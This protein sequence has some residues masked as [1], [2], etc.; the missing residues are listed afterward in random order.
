MHIF[1]SLKRH[2]LWYFHQ[3]SKLCLFLEDAEFTTESRSAHPHCKNL[4]R[5]HP[6]LPKLFVKNKIMFWLLFQE[7]ARHPPDAGDKATIKYINNSCGEREYWFARTCLK[8]FIVKVLINGA[9]VSDF[10]SFT[11]TWL[12]PGKGKF[13]VEID[14]GWR[15]KLT[16]KI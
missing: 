3:G 16:F 10:R 12:L 5:P 8:C 13:I 9:D 4:L 14:F 6:K 15:L 7:P 1:F 11:V 2:L